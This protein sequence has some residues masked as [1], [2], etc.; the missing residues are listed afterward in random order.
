MMSVSQ[1][2]EILGV[3]RDS[4]E[5]ALK[6]AYKAVA[7]QRHPDHGGAEEAFQA[8]QNAF[9]VLCQHQH[10]ERWGTSS[11]VYGSY[12]KPAPKLIEHKG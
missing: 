6:A 1:A 12:V 11:S 8:V 3:R 2:E 7:Q 5:K 10:A 9:D 4:S